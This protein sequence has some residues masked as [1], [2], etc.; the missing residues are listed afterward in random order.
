MRRLGTDRRGFLRLL[1]GAAA[2][3]ALAQLPPARMAS[4]AC[5]AGEGEGA[6][7]SG[8]FFS[9][10]EREI[11]TQVVERLVD[12]GEPGAPAVRATRTI[13]VIDRLC[14]GLDPELTRPLTA[15]LQLVEWGPWVFDLAFSR[16]TLLDAAA[17]DASLR[18]WM[19]SRF[20]LR[21]RGFLALRNLASFG[22]WSQEET[23]PLIGYAGPLLRPGERP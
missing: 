10:T 21:R 13:D 14:A 9:D 7:S 1:G 15:L 17:Q 4:A 22:Y 2:L 16:F 23:W 19:T 8:R 12:S 20:A 5:A 11:L 6:D 18:G 3:G